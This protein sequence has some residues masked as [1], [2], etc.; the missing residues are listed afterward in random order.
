MFDMSPITPSLAPNHGSGHLGTIL[1]SLSTSCHNHFLSC[2]F[3]L[4]FCLEALA[5]L[6]YSSTPKSHSMTSPRTLIVLER[7]PACHKQPRPD[8]VASS[9]RWEV[10]KSL[11]TE[12][13]SSQQDKAGTQ[14][15]RHKRKLTKWSQQQTGREVYRSGLFHFTDSQLVR[16]GIFFQSACPAFRCLLFYLQ[17]RVDL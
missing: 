16:Y 12:S 17:M 13:G 7:K 3:L 9:S 1:S 15:V 4:L 2:P 6:T 8:L 11:V 14:Q 10:S 5:S